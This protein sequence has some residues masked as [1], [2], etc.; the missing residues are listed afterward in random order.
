LQF[1]EKWCKK[2]T[3]ITSQVEYVLALNA[4]V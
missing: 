1:D 2:H 3:G 4:E